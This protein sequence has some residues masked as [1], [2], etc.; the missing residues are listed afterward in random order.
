MC[1]TLK[2]QQRKFPDSSISQIDKTNRHTDSD[3]EL[4][5]YEKQVSESNVFQNLPNPFLYLLHI[6]YQ[7]PMLIHIRFL[8]WLHLYLSEIAIAIVVQRCYKQPSEVVHFI[9]GVARQSTCIMDGTQLV[10]F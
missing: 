4:M 3:A 1:Q 8:K 7:P 9:K 10:G 5:I 6:L 2:V